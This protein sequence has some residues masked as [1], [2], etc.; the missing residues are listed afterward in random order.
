MARISETELQRRLK[1]L[2][3]KAPSGG[4]S[5]V[6]NS[7]PTGTNYVDGDTH[8]DSVLNN[9]WLFNDGTWTLTSK[10]LHIYY[11]DN[12]SNVNSDGTVNAQND[13]TGFSQTPFDTSGTQKAWR[14]LWW[15]PTDVASTDPTDY[16]WTLTSGE[17][18]QDG[19]DGVD[20][21]D[22]NDG[23]SVAQLTVFKR[24]SSAASTPTGGSYNFSTN[25]ITPP[26]GWST[27]VPS[28]T[29]P[30]Y[31]SHA[32]ASVSGSTGTDSSLTWSSPEIIS[33]NGDDGSDGSNGT[34][35]TSVY[36][37]SVFRRQSTSPSTPLANTGSFNFTTNVL[38]A[39]TG[40]PS[41]ETWSTSVPAGTDPLYACE[42]T[43]SISG[44]TGTDSTVTW[45]TPVKVVEDGADGNDGLST[46]LFSIFKRS[47]TALNTPTGGS[48]N[49]TSNSATAPT[50][51]ST[52]VPSGTDP[53]Y[54]STTLASVQGPTGTDSS[55]TWSYPTIL[56]KDGESP[57]Y[58]RYYTDY[59][60]LLSELGDPDNAGTGVTWTAFTGS[61][62]SS[63]YWV[64]E[65]FVIGTDVSPWAIYPVQA[66]EGGIPFVRSTKAGYNKPTL[67]D[68]TW[69][70]DAVA[71]VSSFTG[72]S[73]SNQKE[74]GYGTVVVIEYDNGKLAGKYTRSG[75][76]DTWV[77]P[78]EFID[79]DL[80]VDGTIAAEK[81]QAASIDAT[82]I[83]VTG[84]NA[85][86]YTTV[87]A[88]PS[89]AAA[90]AESNAAS[91]AT[92]KA[93]I[94]ESNA[95]S[96]ASADATSKAN[97]AESNATSTAA[98]D[99]TSK[100]NTAESNATSTAAAD[101]TSKANT[102]E[103]NAISTASADATSKANTAESN[104][105]STA[106]A[107]A[108]SKVAVVTNNI[109]TPNTTSID[110]GVITTG[111]IVANSIAANAITADKMAANS[112]RAVTIDLDDTINLLDDNSG[113]ASGK[114]NLSDFANEGIYVGNGTDT[115]GNQISGINVSNGSSVVSFRSDGT[116]AMAGVDFY[117]TV[118][119]STPIEYTS[120]G[121]Y[122]LDISS[123]ST[124][125][126][127]TIEMIGGG[128]GGG[129]GAYYDYTGQEDG[130]P[131]ADGG[132]S[133]A[134]INNSTSGNVTYTASGGT[135]APDDPFTGSVRDYRSSPYGEAG[136]SSY[137]GSGGSA[138]GDSSTGDT[139]SSVEDGGDAASTAY[140]AGGGGHG[141]WDS[142]S[143]TYH[144]YSSYGGHAATRSVINYSKRAGD[145][146]ISITVG[147][148][149]AGTGA[150]GDGAGGYMKITPAGVVFSN[151]VDLSP[152]R[153]PSTWSTVYLTGRGTYDG[154]PAGVGWY[155]LQPGYTTT[156][157]G[158]TYYNSIIGQTIYGNGEHFYSSGT[159]PIILYWANNVKYSSNYD[160]SYA[161]SRRKYFYKRIA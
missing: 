60:G 125:D 132:D 126:N 66:K 9:L 130:F 78:A 41:S 70:T 63:A 4:T 103:S 158:N 149:G 40:N 17:N 156:S 101:A 50:G 71:A 110:G 105:I 109:Y 8:Y 64:A 29:D 56:A 93:N 84:T 127:I 18:G 65:K 157:G 108:T 76:S 30:V 82:K 72:R 11:A 116:F 75:T 90:T 92:T 111:T 142:S 15:G 138:G 31:S 80:V 51:W 25:V 48:Y 140:G 62:P 154:P 147:A 21:T 88:D 148:L 38:T 144:R 98:A 134:V 123:L 59:P 89:G 112:V 69:I 58:T 85:I 107:D 83:V 5:Y 1:A 131:G 13:V 129:Q 22:G 133:I 19:A 61:A 153:D 79:G 42:A 118:S 53:V 136:E 37:T 43:F 151:P 155:L 139:Y 45:S 128:G 113:I 114:T 10:Q 36:T 68:S 73:Y 160:S 35:G 77:D 24:S 33:K 143:G 91:D 3:K 106:S 67:G 52:S 104:A 145:T 95:I 20:G 97:T 55:L 34:D 7:S 115:S 96:T 23:N 28:G 16:E 2:E 102:A 161:S 12:V 46:Y 74:F 150:G 6:G 122:T 141:A 39:P 135:G 49:F 54:T 121:T 27:S 57:T 146:T 14:G 86:T 152:M 119:T 47:S 124:G 94:A 44:D 32:I 120:A 81:I 26:T 99:A 159:E 137:Y 100:A 87:G 117:G